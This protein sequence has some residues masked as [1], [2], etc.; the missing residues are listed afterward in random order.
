MELKLAENLRY[1]LKKHNL[2]VT[3]L[4][5]GAGLPYSTCHDAVYGAPVTRP[6]NVARLARYFQ[7]S[8]EQILFER[9]DGLE[10]TGAPIRQ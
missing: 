8:M 2:T 6:V 3:E 5:R 10:D 1:L 7:I 9:I 4:A